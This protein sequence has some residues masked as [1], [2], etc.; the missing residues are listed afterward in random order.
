M[1]IVDCPVLLAQVFGYLIYKSE[2]N[3]MGYT[4]DGME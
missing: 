1:G 4:R 2:Y 3:E